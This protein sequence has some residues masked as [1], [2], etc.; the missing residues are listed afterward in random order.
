[1]DYSD[2]ARQLIEVLGG[3]ANVH[4][5][6]VC[7]TRLRI[8]LGNSDKAD[9]KMAAELDG[10]LGVVPR[11]ANAIE[12]VFG[13]RKVE[14]VHR[15]IL[16]ELGGVE[17]S[18]TPAKVPFENLTVAISPARRHSYAKQAEA[19]ASLLGE[20]ASSAKGSAAESAATADDK[21][22]PRV[23]VINGPNINLLGLREPDV[24]G[25]EDYEALIACC[26]EAASEA[27]FSECR[28]YQSN[29]EGDLIDRIQRAHGRYDG[30]VI[31]PGAYTHTSIAL[32]DA[33][34]AVRIPAVEVH[35]S[36][37]ESRESFRQ[38]SYVRKWCFKT[39]SG[40]G[41]DGYR[42]AM[43]ALAEE[44]GGR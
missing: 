9:L 12:V 37:V 26:R 1:M 24:Y 25:S 23:L 44:L 42:E 38:I 7:M 10:V 15:A 8:T 28:I 17:D 13:P 4:A 32:L 18:T 36:D 40:K 16:S 35:I 5:C 41:I 14:E 6:N 19:L 34:T 30:I 27:G 3:N 39:I 29:H 2:V 22:G 43:V 31:N 21:A 11:T 33:L 20:E